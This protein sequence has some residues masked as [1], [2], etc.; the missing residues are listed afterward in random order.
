M[1]VR[2]KA[3]VWRICSAY[4]THQ[5]H[6]TRCSSTWLNVRGVQLSLEVIGDQLHKLLTR[7]LVIGRAELAGQVAILPRGRI[8]HLGL[9]ARRRFRYAAASSK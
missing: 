4:V 9:S 3:T 8:V 6:I 1:S 2:V 5:S 7:D